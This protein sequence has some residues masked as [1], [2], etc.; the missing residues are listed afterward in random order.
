ML[1]ACEVKPASNIKNNL[2]AAPCLHSPSTVQVSPRRPRARK[3]TMNIRFRFF[4][5]DVNW[6]A[7]GGKWVSPKQSNGEFD[8]WLVL[9]LVNMDDGCGRDNEGHARYNVTLSAVSPSE[10]GANTARA[11]ASYGI[12]ANDP[13]AT[14]VLA[15]VECLHSYGIHVPLW[16]GNGNNAHKL[17]REARRAARPAT[18]LFGFYMDRAVNRIGTTGWEAIRGDITAGLHRASD[19]NSAAAQAAGQ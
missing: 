7:Y 9:E 6:L 19:T 5:G 17:L 13:A 1:R 4:T 11:L 12:D 10:A 3:E 15:Q 16:I 2:R 14:N 8:Y 18:G